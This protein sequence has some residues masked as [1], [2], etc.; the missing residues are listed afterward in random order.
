MLVFIRNQATM[1]TAQ[2][3]DFAT[4]A[5][6]FTLQD[7]TH[8]LTFI[9]GEFF[10]ESPTSVHGGISKANLLHLLQIKQSFAVRQGMQGHDTD[11]GVGKR[12]VG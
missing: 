6:G 9:G 3:I 7:E 12:C 10:V 4:N 11:Q 5:E 8:H 2:T 1:A